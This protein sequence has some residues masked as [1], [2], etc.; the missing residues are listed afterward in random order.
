MKQS[1]A[2]HNHTRDQRPIYEDHTTLFTKLE[3]VKIFLTAPHYLISISCTS[4]DLQMYP[5][6]LLTLCSFGS[7]ST[8]GFEHARPSL[9]RTSPAIFAPTHHPFRLFTHSLTRAHTDQ[10][11]LTLPTHSRPTACALRDTHPAPPL[12]DSG[13]SHH[14]GLRHAVLAAL[15]WP[16]LA[17]RPAHAPRAHTGLSPRLGPAGPGSV[18]PRTCTL[19][20]DRS[21][22]PGRPVAHRRSSAFTSRSVPTARPRFRPDGPA[23]EARCTPAQ[24]GF[25]LTLHLV[26]NSHY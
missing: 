13:L 26:H 19:G 4:S 2:R 21:A 24:L 10:G 8:K 3:G 11:P 14:S 16:R 17:P 15:S 1:K 20:L 22:R 18:R 5:G 23:R 12:D 25:H 9:H 6:W 7:R